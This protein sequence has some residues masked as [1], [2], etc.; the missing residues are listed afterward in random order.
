LGFGCHG[1]CAV[2]AVATC[3]RDYYPPMNF[4]RIQYAR[5]N[6]RQKENYNFQK[7]SN[8][9][10]DYGFST[11]EILRRL[12]GDGRAVVGTVSWEQKG[13]YGFPT[14]PL[15]LEEIIRPHFLPAL[16]IL[17]PKPLVLAAA[18]AASQPAT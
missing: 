3:P 17:A 1:V 13:R 7:V 14:T 12:L 9:L 6:D 4:A 16:T 18:S 10:A 8:V 15:W 5:L 11:I 2:F